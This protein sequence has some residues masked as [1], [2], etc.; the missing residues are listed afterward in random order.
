MRTHVTGYW[1]R[2]EVAHGRL[3]ELTDPAPGLAIR[4]AVILGPVAED[5]YRLTPVG[6]ELVED[7]HSSEEYDLRG[8]RARRG[9]PSGCARVRTAAGRRP[10]R[11]RRRLCA[12]MCASVVRPRTAIE[13]EAR[14]V[15]TGVA[16][17]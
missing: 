12:P 16:G 15:S 3:H 5:G 14:G 13:D 7:D 2:A 9:S 4:V 1:R 10:A 8:A 11:R 17:A 6:E